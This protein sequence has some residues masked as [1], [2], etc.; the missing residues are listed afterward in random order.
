MMKKNRSR[1]R[2]LLRNRYQPDI[3][4]NSFLDLILNVLLFFIF[5]TEIAVF[6]AIEVK[7]PVT[8]F[9]ESV[10]TP[11]EGT[12]IYIS[13]DNKLFADNHPV[14]LKELAQWLSAKKSQASFYGIIVR[15]D[16]DSNLQT[17]VDVMAACRAVGIDKIK[18]ETEKPK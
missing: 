2:R 4:L 5:A 3:N 1:A 7:V 15:G 6:D 14:A 13:K 16:L 18:V 11:K 12:I 10:S 17:M 9:S 8:E